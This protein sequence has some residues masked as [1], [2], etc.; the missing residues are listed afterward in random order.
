M[1]NHNTTQ[2]DL[3]GTI[4]MLATA[5]EHSIKGQPVRNAPHCFAAAE[6]Y[7]EGTQYEFRLHTS[8]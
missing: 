7:T 3:L 4:Q 1:P 2:E 5:L 6:R 8:R